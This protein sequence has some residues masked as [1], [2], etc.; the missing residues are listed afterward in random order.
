[1]T[2]HWGQYEP[3][4]F[5]LS[6]PPQDAPRREARQ[7]YERCMATRFERIEMLNWLLKANGVKRGTSDE[8]VQALHEWF[9]ES[10]E[11]EPENVGYPLPIWFSSYTPLRLYLAKP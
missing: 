5:C 6:C 11:P 8:A 7:T 2:I 4:D 3:Y 1:M 9:V 10:L